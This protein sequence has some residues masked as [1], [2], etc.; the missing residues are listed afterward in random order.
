MKRIVTAIAVIVCAAA[1]VA[2]STKPKSP[3]KDNPQKNTILVRSEDATDQDEAKP[4]PC[5]NYECNCGGRLYYSGTAWKEY[6][7]C[8]A[9]DG[10]GKLGSP[11]IG[12]TKCGYC[13]GT[14]KNSR[15]HGGC[16]CEK[17]GKV[18]EQPEGC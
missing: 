9:C 10:T 18:Y 11:S 3:Q 13:D 14:G 7:K 1:F 4:C 12:Y 16:V 2:F 6:Y 8:T 15:W 5:S 17:C